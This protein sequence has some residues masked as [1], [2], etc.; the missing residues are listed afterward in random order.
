MYITIIHII[1]KSHTLRYWFTWG[2]RH[3]EKTGDP[4]FN[5]I[6]IL[7]LSWRRTQH[8]KLIF[9]DIWFTIQRLN[10]YILCEKKKKKKKIKKK[11]N[12]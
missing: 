1:L 2:G 11:K 7:N 12:C 5:F 3:I 4:A 8:K 10:K 6:C 9:I